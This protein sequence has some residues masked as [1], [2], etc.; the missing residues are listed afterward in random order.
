M[1]TPPAD[2]ERKGEQVT[3]RRAVTRCY[4]S[5]S[6]F[7]TRTWD[8]ETGYQA[9]FKSICEQDMGYPADLDFLSAQ[10]ISSSWI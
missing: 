5:L 3:P 1:E 9:Q 7:I 6:T 10:M 8:E 2:S 4:F